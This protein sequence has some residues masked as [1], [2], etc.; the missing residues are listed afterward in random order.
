MKKIFALIAVLSALVA[1]ETVASAQMDITYS[2]GAGDTFRA[3]YFSDAK[4]VTA[5]GLSVD[6]EANFR[7]SNRFAFSAGASL[8]GTIG[9][10]FGGNKAINLGEIFVRVPLRAKVYIPLGGRVEM[11]FFGGFV[12]E[13]CLVSVDAHSKNV[14]DNFKEN[15][16]LRRFDLMAGAGVGLE[17]I[18]HIKVS[19]GYDHGIMDRD[20]SAR[21]AHTGLVKLGVA[22]IF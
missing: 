22:Y 3:Y 17:I 21:K 11:Y 20:V 1:G 4:S 9:Y 13:L 15:P 6:F 7:P 18:D 16:N 8:D 2:I 12:P 10:H 19:L 5:P 14:T